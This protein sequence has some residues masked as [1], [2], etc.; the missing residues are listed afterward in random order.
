MRAL[1]DERA[2][3]NEIKGNYESALTFPREIESA[4]IFLTAGP[5]EPA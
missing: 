2:L 4:H 1:A 5:S 3:C